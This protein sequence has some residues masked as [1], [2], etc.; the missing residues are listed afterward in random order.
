MKDK[1]KRPD[2]QNRGKYQHLE[3]AFFNNPAAS[4]NDCT[5]YVNTPPPGHE[6]AENLSDLLNAPTS[7]L[8]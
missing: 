2:R 1:P 6:E 5:G 3:Q 7:P 8:T 4:A